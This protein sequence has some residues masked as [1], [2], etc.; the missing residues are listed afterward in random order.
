MNISSKPYSD[1]ARWITL[2]PAYMNSKKK[3]AEG[4][5][6]AVEKAVENP[7]VQ[8]MSEIVNHL[9]LKAKVE[10]NKMYPRDSNR[11]PALQGRLRVQLKNDDGTYCNDEFKSRE[12]LMLHIAEL[13]PKLKSR[14]AGGGAP[15]PSAAA[16]GGKKKKK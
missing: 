12:A 2:Y 16:G 8:E 6:I 9:K 15:A 7:T 10:K 1:E 11:D 4:R 13:I 14:Q 3:K 5:R